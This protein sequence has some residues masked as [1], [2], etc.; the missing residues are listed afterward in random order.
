MTL[1]YSSFLLPFL[2]LAEEGGEGV[3]ASLSREVVVMGTI[4]E[5][6]LYGRSVEEL[7]TIS[8]GMIR[9]IEELEEVLSTW[10]PKSELSQLNRAPLKKWQRI[11]EELAGALAGGIHCYRMT[12]GYFDPGIL[13]LEE[14]WDMRGKGRIPSPQELKE[15][16]PGIG[17]KYLE[18]QGNQARRLS[19]AMMIEE[20]GFAKGL[21]LREVLKM[22]KN[23]PFPFKGYLNLGGQILLLG[24]V[25]RVEIAD[26]LKRESP[27]LALSVT[28]GSVST[29]SQH[30]RKII[31]NGKSYGHI[32]DPRTG[33]PV[34]FRG[35]ITVITADPLEADCFSTALL[36]MPERRQEEWLRSHPEVSAI[37]L[38]PERD[39]Y[40]VRITPD[41]K[42]RVHPL[43]KT[44]KEFRFELYS[45]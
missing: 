10:E 19:P 23:Q 21:A 43:K 27:L 31:L 5:V 26:P 25:E 24:G 37:T 15:L 4:L 28:S 22:V 38:F 1:P 20:G 36:V 39:G 3:P 33:F 35:S 16:L 30:E 34:P 42:G 40:R 32:L 44:G 13:A 29:S 7:R 11:S 12:E 17:I 18:L 14:L 6:R 9:T 8:E 45:R 41:L 2:L